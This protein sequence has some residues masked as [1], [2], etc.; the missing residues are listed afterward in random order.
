MT[1]KRILDSM[2]LLSAVTIM[3][4][5]VLA[6]VPTVE[7][8]QWETTSE[9]FFISHSD[10][11]IRGIATNQETKRDEETRW[12]YTNTSFTVLEVVLGEVALREIIIRTQGGQ[13]GNITHYTADVPWFDVGAEYFPFPE[14]KHGIT[15]RLIP[16]PLKEC[17]SLTAMRLSVGRTAR[18]G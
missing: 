3:S 16:T 2:K 4:I 5:Y 9:D 11:V 12:M 15:V 6:L 10:L 17:T 18:S 14:E 7:G 1:T 8:T 13:I